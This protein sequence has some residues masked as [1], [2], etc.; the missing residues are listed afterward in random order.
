MAAQVVLLPWIITDLI[1]TLMHGTGFSVFTAPRYHP[2][3]D[4]TQHI[5]QWGH[6]FPDSRTAGYITCGR[7]TTLWTLETSIPKC[8]HFPSITWT[9]TA[10]ISKSC[11]VFYQPRRKKQLNMTVTTKCNTYLRQQ[12]SLNIWMNAFSTEHNWWLCTIPLWHAI[13]MVTTVVVL[14]WRFNTLN[15]CYLNK[16]NGDDAPHKKK[17]NSNGVPPSKTHMQFS[18]MQCWTTNCQPVQIPR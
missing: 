12:K 10:E 5:K 17:K 1:L 6:L 8:P 15:S 2:S 7:N 9:V 18:F 13:Q 11:Q 3:S 4:V 14:N 16:H